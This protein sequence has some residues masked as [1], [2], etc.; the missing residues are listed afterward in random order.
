MTREHFVVLFGDVLH[1][2][3]KGITARL[4]YRLADLRLSAE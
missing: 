1:R 2:Q 4:P 3:H